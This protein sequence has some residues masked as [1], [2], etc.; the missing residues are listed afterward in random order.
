MINIGVP[1][2]GRGSRFAGIE[3]DAPKPLIQVVPGKAMIEYVIDYLTLPEP[4]RF[5]FICLAAHER[6]HNFKKFFQAKTR[7]HQIVLARE[8]TAGPAASALLAAPFV[9]NENELLVAY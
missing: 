3:D 9:D 8:I 2:A 6:L 7:G 4:H 1:M 5:I